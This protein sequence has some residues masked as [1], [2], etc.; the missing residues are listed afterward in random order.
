VKYVKENES[1]PAGTFEKEKR[2]KVEEG[3]NRKAID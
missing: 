1:C 2:V 3:R